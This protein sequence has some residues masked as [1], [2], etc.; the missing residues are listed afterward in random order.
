[1][2]ASHYKSI[3]MTNNEILQADMLDILFEHRNKL[4]GA[5]TLRRNYNRRMIVALGAAPLTALLFFL[6]SYFNRENNDRN[7]L[8]KN[9]GVVSLTTIDLNNDKPKQPEKPKT[10]L[11]TQPEKAK[12][13]FQ[14]IVVVKDKDAD[15]LLPDLDAIKNADISNEN[16]NGKPSDDLAKPTTE[17]NTYGTGN[18]KQKEPETIVIDERAPEFPGGQATWISFLR[19]F[20]QSPEEL[21]PGQRVS[22]LIKFWVDI[23]GSIS[24]LEVIKSGGNSFD[25]EVLRVMKKMP[26]WE[27]ALQNGHKTAVA[28]TQPVSFVGAEE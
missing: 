1:M 23:D 11:K 4:Y 27:P 15:P 17:N 2:T 8:N 25:K 19:K 9:N 14:K 18:V 20:L 12:V 16:K 5:Y 22:V 7:S 3:A 13:D 21:E 10:K 24:R 6:I 26:K 28:F